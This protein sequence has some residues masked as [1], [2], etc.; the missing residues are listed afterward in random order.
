MQSSFFEV[1]QHGDVALLV[2]T[3]DRMTE[4][5]NLEQLDRDWVALT[6]TYQIRHIVLDLSA[7]QYM[8]S[9]AIA[10]LI[11]LHRRLVRNEGQLVLC[12]LQPEV[13]GTLAT[14]HLLSYFKVAGTPAEALALYA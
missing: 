12:S 10:K 13:T 9:A 8:T 5:E 1:Q 11:A 14:S 2:L 7:V 6:D 3:P 4:E